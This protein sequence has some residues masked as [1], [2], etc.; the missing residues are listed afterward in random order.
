[1]KLD[2]KKILIIILLC[3]YCTHCSVYTAN[4]FDNI[5]TELGLGDECVLE[6]NTPGTCQLT[7]NCEYVKKKMSQRKH[8]EIKICGFNRR[9]PIVCCPYDK[10]QD[11]NL[12][13][14]PSNLTCK[15]KNTNQNLNNGQSKFQKALCKDLIPPVKLDMHIIGGEK[16]EV[17]EF[18]FQVALGY[19][20]FDEDELEFKC[21]GSLIADDVI[22]TAA[23]C[24]NKKDKLPV[25]ARIGRTSLD[26]TDSDDDTEA[27][28]IKIEVN[29]FIFFERVNF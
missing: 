27:Q 10:P 29:K 7:A 5:N 13:Q 2:S 15:I 25:M 8:N 6:N 1:M 11:I 9:E 16:A 20:N 14:S 17:G 18:K 3:C 22:I 28:D 19:V 4:I 23:H 21:G 24:V 12:N 26:L